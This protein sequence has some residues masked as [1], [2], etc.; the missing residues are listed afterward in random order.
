ML[1]KIKTIQDFQKLLLK[2][3]S[4]LLLLF[5]LFFI[6]KNIKA[7]SVVVNG[8]F[9]AADPRDEWTEL[10]V[11]DDNVDMRNWTIRDNNS[12]QDNWQTAVTFRNI[13][14][15]NNMRA[16]TII[17]IWH[18]VINSSLI[19]HPADF[20]KE[21]GYIEINAQ[22]TAFFSG[23]AFGSSPS[24]GGNS[25]NIA[26]TG[27]IIQ[28]RN[29]SDTHIH[30]L[31]HKSSPGADWT[32]LPTPKLNHAN[33]AN[34][35]DAIYVC[36]GGNISQYNGP[37]GTSLTSKNNTTITFGLP[38][39]CGSAPND[40]TNFI[41]SL[42]EPI[43]TS[44]TVNATTSAT[45]P[46][47]ALTFTW[48]AAT[49]PV[50]SD[51]TQ[52][53]MIVRS[54]T[55][56]FGTPQDGFTYNNGDAIPGG[57]TVIAHIDNTS[58][59]T[60][61]YTDYDANTSGTF[62]YRVYAYRY[63]TDDLN[64]NNYHS[65]RGRAYNTTNYVTVNCITNPLPITL[66]EFSVKKDKEKSLIHWTT[67]SEINNDYFVVERS[68]DAENFYEIS[69]VK[70]AGN[71]NTIL[72]YQ[73]KDYSPLSGTNYYRLK[74]VDFDGSYTYSD[75]KALNFEKNLSPTVYYYDNKLHINATDVIHNLQIEIYD[76]CGKLIYQNNQYCNSNTITVNINQNLENGMYIAVIR[77]E[78]Q[79]N[80][81]KFVISK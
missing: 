43:F 47:V 8:Y 53:Y 18:R 37:S 32:A 73:V 45:Y 55:G 16:G 11:I 40:N 46:T 13:A 25:L 50:H 54:N 78:E 17:I 44:Q 70:G 74:Q 21:D 1:K 31:G 19:T 10:V 5:L 3:V 51:Q 9:N 35:G 6:S 33:N 68:N 77:T 49:D 2:I 27:D 34:N 20:N 79:Q 12:D 30:A 63:Y 7:Q 62:C 80:S 48:N 22:N 71:S 52:G 38:N 41:R 61:T 69:K 23:G 75:I 56:V 72:N 24:W 81:Y 39:T 14:F 57:G 36:P 4:I 58:A 26:A 59:S 64:G 76:V 42:R 29:A 60:F 65:A 67:I 28:I 15:W 66:S